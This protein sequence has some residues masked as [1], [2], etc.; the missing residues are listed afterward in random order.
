[1]VSKSTRI[2]D[3]W[4]PS[5]WRPLPLPLLLPLPLQLPPAACQ[6][7]K[8]CPFLEPAP[9]FA[10]RRPRMDSTLP[11]I[12]L[13]EHYNPKFAHQLARVLAP[14]VRVWFRF[15][16]RGVERLPAGQPVLLVGNHS[17]WGTAELLCLLV[18]WLQGVGDKRRVNGL[19]HDVTFTTP[20]VGPFY[21]G[22]GAIGAT[23]ANACSALD[24]GHDVLVYPGGDLDACRPFY[25]PRA[26]HFGTR[27]GYIRLALQT[28]VPVCPLAT[29][30]SHY[31]WLMA[32][33]G[34]LFSKWF[35]L[36]QR[37]RSERIPLPFEW[38]TLLIAVPAWLF[39]LV[40]LWAFALIAVLALVPTPARITTQVLP[41][42]D[43]QAATAEL[44]DPEAKVERAHQIVYGALADAVARM[45]HG[46]PLSLR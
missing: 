27:R 6:R 37:L 44:S 31:S 36:K 23:A 18:G 22:L 32:P 9:Q 14:V 35:G 13:V 42:I 21:R 19:M 7:A 46:R 12:P 11:Q 16:L 10:P 26:V 45:E 1:M 3:D 29:I 33:G 4:H 24:A 40:P 25:Q 28:G 15:E 39:G 34:A 17:A 8:C 41:P 43:L 20:L 30:G 5:G 2:V 38:L